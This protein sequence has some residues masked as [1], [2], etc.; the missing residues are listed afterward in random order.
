MEVKG[1]IT[2]MVTPM[3]D[4]QEI[5]YEMLRSL[6]RTLIDKGIHGLFI[7]GT[8]GEFYTLTNEEKIK[9]AQTVIAE[10][11]HAVPIFVGTG[12][13]STAETIIQCKIMEKL[14]ADALSVITPY[15]MAPTQQELIV[16]Y[17]SVAAS[18]DIP[19][20]MYNMPKN[21]GINIEP[22]TTAIL[23]E[24]K[25][26]IAIKDSS[27]NLANMKKYIELTKGMGFSVLS[28]SDS[29]I[30]DLLIA[31]GTG[32]VAATSNIL[33]EIDVAIYDRFV[34]GN[35]V[36]AKN[37]QKSIEEFRRILKLGTTPTILKKAME[38]YGLK[39]GPARLPASSPSNEDVIED[40]KK[41][42]EIYKLLIANKAY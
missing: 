2:A 37:A 12:A 13:C 39:V 11:N 19:I 26:I 5:D 17:Q 4:N 7:L 18:V 34:A 38:F 20:I 33:T 31:G 6:T 30:L 8:N 22:E 27:G 10:A 23:A 35:L 29:L 40:I 9:I 41:V 21:T 32:A 36:E 14:G 24:V 1:I 25:N 16:H 15:F 28:G 3:R 42:V